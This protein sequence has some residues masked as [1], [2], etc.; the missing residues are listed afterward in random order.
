MNGMNYLILKRLASYP[1][2]GYEAKRDR[3]LTHNSP[4]G[5]G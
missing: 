1:E 5:Y 3:K 4:T 2:P